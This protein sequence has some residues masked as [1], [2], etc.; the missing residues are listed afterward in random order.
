VEDFPASKCTGHFTSILGNG[1]YPF[2]K[3]NAA[4]LGGRIGTKLGEIER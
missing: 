3:E 4:K 2:G 1:N